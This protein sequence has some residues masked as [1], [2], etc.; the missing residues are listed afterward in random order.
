[1]I[2]SSRALLYLSRVRRPWRLAAA[3]IAALL[4]GIAAHAQTDEI[5]V[6]DAEINNPGEFSIAASSLVMIGGVS[7]IAAPPSA[8]YPAKRLAYRTVSVSPPRQG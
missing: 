6:Y 8:S 5:Q 7:V 4:A 2:L 3:T 1:M